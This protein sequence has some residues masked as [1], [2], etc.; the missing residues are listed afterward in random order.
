[1]FKLWPSLLSCV[2]I[3]PS[4]IIPHVSIKGTST[5][6]ELPARSEP[7]KWHRPHLG[8][9]TTTIKTQWVL[10]VTE[11]E[12]EV[13]FIVV[14]NWLDWLC[15]ILTVKTSWLRNYVALISAHKKTGL[16]KNDPLWTNNSYTV[17]TQFHS[18]QKFHLHKQ[19]HYSQTLIVA[20]TRGTVQQPLHMNTSYTAKTGFLQVMTSEKA[21]TVAQSICLTVRINSLFWQT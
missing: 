12:R 11:N 14:G 3:T 13:V 21:D 19:S 15:M 7:K 20:H 4:H 2:C 8:P 1:M 18:W 17:C 5:G 6:R 9:A 16:E 10:M